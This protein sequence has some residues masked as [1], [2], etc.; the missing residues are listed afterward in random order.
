MPLARGLQVG[1][2]L[3][4]D[5]GRSSE[6]DAACQQSTIKVMG[7]RLLTGV[8]WLC[9]IGR[10]IHP[11]RRYVST[12]P[13]NPRSTHRPTPISDPTTLRRDVHSR[14][15]GR[16]FP[17]GA[18]A[19][20]NLGG[21]ATLRLG[22]VGRGVFEETGQDVAG[23]MLVGVEEG[24][25]SVVV[26][27]G[28]IGAA[29]EQDFDRRGV[30]QLRGDVQ[31]GL[32]AGVCE[33]GVEAVGQQ[34]LEDG[35]VAMEGREVEGCPAG[36]V[37]GCEEGW[38]AAVFGVEGGQ[39]AGGGGV[40]EEHVSGDGGGVVD[41]WREGRKCVGESLVD[42]LGPG[43]LG[44]LLR[45]EESL[46]SLG[47]R[48]LVGITTA[49]IVRL[50]GQLSLASLTS[51]EISHVRL[52]PSWSF[53]HAI[54]YPEYDVEWYSSIRGILFQFAPLFVSTAAQ[55]SAEQS[56]M[57]PPGWKRT[58]QT[59]SRKDS[60]TSTCTLAQSGQKSLVRG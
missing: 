45:L 60:T 29:L 30:G 57:N 4:V 26:A 54:V 56:R 58:V 24:R 48:G 7:H 6:V 12:N 27:D 13:P 3:R 59:P 2:I 14:R 35:G 19:Q 51:A 11:S 1:V 38:V 36:G 22:G 42:L 15:R 50:F 46:G 9:P 53:N 52:S 5:R 55:C 47:Q 20:D 41:V 16:P 21:Q 8:Q 31:G 37:G 28:R 18:G 25:L 32:A 10:S 49:R 43:D 33:G 34:A 17:A 40:E 39:V 44:A 23:V